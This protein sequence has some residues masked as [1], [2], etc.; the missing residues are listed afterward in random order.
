MIVISDIRASIS[1]IKDISTVKI[2]GVA[3]EK[4]TF[5]SPFLLIKKDNQ[6]VVTLDNEG[7][8]LLD[9][10]RLERSQ[11][12]REIKAGIVSGSISTLSNI[13]SLQQ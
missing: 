7:K 5:Y 3:Y 1:F 6:F 4:N 9:V 8:I 12:I 11:I 10:P 13:L 2:S